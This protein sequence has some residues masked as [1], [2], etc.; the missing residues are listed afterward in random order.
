K[1]NFLKQKQNMRN[2]NWDQDFEHIN[3]SNVNRF[4]VN[5]DGQR[6]Y[7]SGYHNDRGMTSFDRNMNDRGYHNRPDWVNTSPDRYA[8]QPDRPDYAPRHRQAPADYDERRHL[9]NRNPEENAVNRGF[10][11]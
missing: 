5:R 9:Y 6:Q 8:V 2:R 10:M 11:G 1:S 3:Q 4:S 7:D